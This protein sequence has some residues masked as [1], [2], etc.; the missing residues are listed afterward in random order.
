MDTPGA[1][2]VSLDTLKGWF[3]KVA[4]HALG[5]ADRRERISWGF[6]RLHDKQVA[7]KIASEYTYKQLI[8]L[9]PSQ[10]RSLIQ[11][12]IHSL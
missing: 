9:R 10:A 8:D 6:Y 4:D 12:T 1:C 5:T 3:E 7:D 11:K 2:M